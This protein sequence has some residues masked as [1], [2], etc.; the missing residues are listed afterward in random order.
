MHYA[1]RPAVNFY[2]GIGI[3]WPDQ[4]WALDVWI[5]GGVVDRPQNA[6]FGCSLAGQGG[7]RRDHVE[8]FILTLD[9]GSRQCG[10]K[11]RSQRAYW[12][13]ERRRRMHVEWMHTERMHMEV[14]A[15]GVDAYGAIPPQNQGV[16]H[17][18]VH[19]PGF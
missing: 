8:G 17:E 18:Y 10:S 3:G 14:D 13:G 5:D 6:L 16:C 7:M 15:Y 4:G 2:S 19:R 11:P 12:A 9:L 1:W